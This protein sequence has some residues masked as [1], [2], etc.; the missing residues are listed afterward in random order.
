MEEYHVKITV[1]R[2]GESQ[3]VNTTAKTA[4]YLSVL[5][6]VLV[7]IP[8]VGWPYLALCFIVAIKALRRARTGTVGVADRLPLS[9]REIR[10]CRFMNKNLHNEPM[11][12]NVVQNFINQVLNAEREIG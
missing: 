1:E 12:R 7:G 8:Y 9:F 5:G 4:I 10:Y 3:C 6:F 11:Y 2:G